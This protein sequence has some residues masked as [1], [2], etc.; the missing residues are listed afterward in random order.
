MYFGLQLVIPS[1]QDWQYSH[2]VNSLE[3]PILEKGSL[4]GRFRQALSGSRILIVLAMTITFAISPLIEFKQPYVADYDLGFHLRTGEWVLQH[5]AVPRTETFTSVAQGKPWVAYSWLFEALLALLVRE[6]DLVGVVLLSVVMRLA[7]T[8]VTWDL[9]RRIVPRFWVAVVL[10]ALV[11]W[12]SGVLTGPRPVLFTI[13][14]VIVTLDAVAIAERARS[15]KPLWFLIPLF[16][17]WGSIHIQFVTGLSVLGAFALE[18]WLDRLFRPASRPA[19][20]VFQRWLNLGACTAATLVNP[21]G[22]GVWELVWNFFKQPKIY[23][24]IEEMKAANFR[25]GAHYVVLAM[26]IAAGIAIGWRRGVRPAVAM[27]FIFA[28]EQG[29]RSVREMWFTALI[30]AVVI[31]MAVVGNPSEGSAVKFAGREKL[32]V[33]ICVI[34][35]IAGGA[36]Y[37]NLNDDM[38]WMGVNGSFPEAA[39]RFVEAHVP[40]RRIFNHYDWGG[41]LIW[42]LPDRLVAIDGRANNVH[43]QDY[44][45]HARELWAARPGW[46]NAPEMTSADV[47]IAPTDKPLTSVL[48][49]D[50]RFKVVFENRESVVFVPAR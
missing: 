9:M 35:L 14:F 1:L 49:L 6:F 24:M 12:I 8:L 37:Y 27:L 46:E 40:G 19:I 10:T 22:A 42:R 41:Y 30:S 48:R 28:V 17:L 32:A 36:R 50:S 43:Q 34:A 16:A 7:I 18:P 29:F 44:L 3:T 20:P 5:G 31:A 15:A 23:D 4:R 11:S 47:I 2:S 26:A 45:E 39:A 25:V 33:V 21:Y 13:L 38:L